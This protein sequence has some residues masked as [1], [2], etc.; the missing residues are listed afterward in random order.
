MLPCCISRDLQEGHTIFANFMQ[1]VW[2]FTLW[3][4]WFY[5]AFELKEW[6]WS[7]WLSPI[8]WIE[9]YLIFVLSC[10]VMYSILYP[11]LSYFGKCIFSLWVHVNYF[12]SH[13]PADSQGIDSYPAKKISLLKWCKCLTFCFLFQSSSVCCVDDCCCILS[14]DEIWCQADL[15]LSPPLSPSSSKQP[16]GEKVSS[17]FKPYVVVFIMHNIE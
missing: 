13:T 8:L 15:E 10:C 6:M 7:F 9:L 5:K 17:D 12:F 4:L 14:G 3:H 11:V 16:S 1:K 2:K